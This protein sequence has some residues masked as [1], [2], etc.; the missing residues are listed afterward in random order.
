MHEVLKVTPEI[1]KAII[2]NKSESDL[3]E[4]AKKQGFELISEVALNHV[5][6]GEISLEEYH[7]AI[8]QITGGI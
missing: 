6:S 8:P 5:R 2:D 4:I 7:R 3:Y 1:Q